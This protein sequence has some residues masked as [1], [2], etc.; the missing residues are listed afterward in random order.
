MNDYSQLKQTIEMFLRCEIQLVF[1]D[2]LTYESI[3]T[4]LPITWQNAFTFDTPISQIIHYLWKDSLPLFEP[5]YQRLQERILEVAI[6][7]TPSEAYFAYI[8]FNY[9]RYFAFLGRTSATTD[10]ITSRENELGFKLPLDYQ[11]FLLIH[12]GFLLDG[13]PSLGIKPLHKLF[14]IGE[15]IG[16][17]IIESGQPINYDPYRLLCICGD[18]YGDEQCFYYPNSSNHAE[19]TVFWD[20]ETR[21]ISKPIRFENFLEEFLRQEM[22]QEY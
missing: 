22:S 18:G 12:N 10:R 2:T 15:M 20:H 19:D 16:E 14:T 4:H 5:F 9:N 21:E 8:F 3:K 7:I 13:W 11:K 6:A 1:R 17:D